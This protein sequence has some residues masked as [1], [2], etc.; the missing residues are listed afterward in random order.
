M[1]ACFPRPRGMVASAVMTALLITLT[2]YRASRAIA[3]TPAMTFPG[4]RW[5][6]APPES[7][8]VDA[9]KL[10]DAID[11]LAGRTGEDGVRQLVV[12]RNGRV[13][14]QGDDVENVHG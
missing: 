13:I 11:F 3:E 14:W 2:P 1:S 5:E 4:E 6:H 12:V 7:Q 8:G 9:A 10:R